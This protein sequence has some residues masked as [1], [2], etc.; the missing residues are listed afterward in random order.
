MTRW[1]YDES[2]R[3]SAPRPVGE[4]L[5]RLARRLGAPRAASLGALFRRWDDAVG[6][7]IATHV[8]PRSLRDGVL[9]VVAD[10]P[11][12]AT[13]LRY[14]GAQVCDRLAEVLGERLVERIEVRVDSQPDRRR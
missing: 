6:D 3:R 10:G 12:W 14:R 5:D 2:D 11:L 4:G 7:A 8:R 1:W 9:E 13:E